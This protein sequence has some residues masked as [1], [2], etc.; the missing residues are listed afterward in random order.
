[1]LP[2]QICKGH[3][4]YWTEEKKASHWAPEEVVDM[5]RV[6]SDVVERLMGRG[7]VEAWVVEGGE[8]DRGAI[9]ERVAIVG[10]WISKPLYVPARV[11]VACTS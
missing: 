4:W 8:E 10:D 11:E 9:V 5:G 3:E 2:Y 6:C 1:M 7:N